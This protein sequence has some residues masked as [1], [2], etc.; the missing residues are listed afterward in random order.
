MT[1]VPWLQALLAALLFGAS[2]PVA[3]LLLGEVSPVVLAALLYLGS[4]LGVLILKGLMRLSS[5]GPEPEAGLESRDLP[6]LLG[7]LLSGGVAAPVVL[8]LGLAHTPASTASLLL[9]FEAVATVLI[10]ALAFKEAVGPRLWV[11]AGSIAL[12]G[13]LLSLDVKGRLGVSWGA[14]GVVA[15]CLLWGLDNNLTRRISGKDPMRIVLVKGL[16]AGACSLG[17]AF[18]LG[19]S[20]PPW[21]AA[22]KAMGLGF[23]GYGLSI[24]LF[25]LA[26]RG[27]GAARTSSLFGIAPFAG[28]LLSFPCSGSGPPCCS[29]SPCPRCSWGASCSGAS[30]TPITTPTPLRSMSTATATT[31]AITG[32]STPRA[33]RA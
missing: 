26:L 3:K 10:A 8:M 4:G 32:T 23:F 31:T 33:S 1:F 30:G 29:I 5:R 24:F 12:G 7:A 27:L 19:L 6:W 18:S 9:N 20:L 17:L 2:A 22:L 14:L 21:P 25:I 13:I 16:G 11:A 15:A 28:A